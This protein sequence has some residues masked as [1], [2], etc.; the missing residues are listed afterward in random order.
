LSAVPVVRLHHLTRPSDAQGIAA[1]DFLSRHN[2]KKA[3]GNKLAKIK[4]AEFE[5]IMAD[6]QETAAV[7]ELEE[8]LDE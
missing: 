1:N 5:K 2:L 4:R 6:F 7:S 3:S 8:F